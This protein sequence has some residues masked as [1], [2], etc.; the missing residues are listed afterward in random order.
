MKVPSASGPMREMLGVTA[1][2]YGQG[3]GEQRTKGGGKVAL[4]PMDRDFQVR[5][6]GMLYTVCPP[7]ALSAPFLWPADLRDGT[8]SAS[9]AAGASHGRP[10][11]RR[12]RNCRAVARPGRQDRH[13]IGAGA[14]RQNM[15][16]LVGRRHAG[17]S[18]MRAG[19]IWPWLIEV[20]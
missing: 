4:L 19:W 10:D 14:T 6:R 17:P 16:R 13:D 8:R 3:M 20:R 15:A 5:P 1:L 11:F 2:I 12:S 18:R 9:T 7:E